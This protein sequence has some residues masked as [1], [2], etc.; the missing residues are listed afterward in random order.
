[1]NPNWGRIVGHTLLGGNGDRFQ[2][3]NPKE[4]VSDENA[5]CLVNNGIDFNTHGWR[6][7]GFVNRES[8]VLSDQ[9]R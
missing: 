5:D 4:Q 2:K 8:A 7:S 1:M 3:S 6:A 9:S